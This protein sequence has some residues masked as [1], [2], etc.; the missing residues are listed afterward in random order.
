MFLSDASVKRPI[1]MGCL[2]IALSLLGINTYRT[3]NL[4]MMPR[5]DLPYITITTAYPGASPEE[6]ETDIAKRIEDE[7]VAID[8]LKHVTSTCMEDY[9]QTLLEFNL[10]IDVD[11][12]ATDVREKIDLI[13]SDLPEDV[14]DPIILKYDINAKPIITMAL[15]GD[16]PLDELYDYADNTL[17]DRISVLSG[18][19]DVDLIG[20]A[21]REVQILLDRE[22]LASR[23]LTTIDVVKAVSEGVRTIPSGRIREGETEYSVKFKAEYDEFKDIG[24]L[25]IVNLQGRRCY[26]RDLGRVEMGTEELRQRADLDGHPCVAIKVVKKSD[27]NAV[28]V[29]HKV[30]EVLDRINRDLPGGMKLVWVTDDGT[31]TEATNFSAWINVLQGIFLTAGILFLFL[32]NFRALMVVAVTMPVTVVIGIFFMG[33]I[34]L[35][36]NMPTLLAIGM[37]VGILVTNSIVV[38][39]AIVKHLKKTG[40]PK[41]AARKGAAESFIAVLASAGTNLVVLFPMSIMETLVGKFIESF[42]QT[43]LIMT[44]VSLFISFTL[45]PLLC[46]VILRPDREEKRNRL[47]RMESSWDRG[48]ERFREKYRRMLRFFEAHRWASILFV[49]SVAGLLILT[50]STAGKMGFNLVNEPDKG[51]I[52]V[53]LEFPTNYSLEFTTTRIAPVVEKLRSIPE[54]GHILTTIGK[55]AGTTGQ[56][57]EGVYLAQ[58]LLRFSEKT[59]RDL[60]LV[61]LADQIR[62]LTAN[63]PDSI[64][65][66]SLPSTMGG[67]DSAVEMEITG[68]KLETLDNLALETKTLAEKIPGILDPDTTVRAGKPELRITPDRAVLAD[69]SYPATTLGM[70]LRG[71]LEGI[72]AATFKKDARNYDITVQLDEVEGKDQV[73]SFL[74]P[75]G[76]GR[77]ITL[78]VLADIEERTTPIQIIRKDKLRVSKLYA[79]LGGRVALGTAVTRI[80]DSIDAK[81]LMPPGYSY[82]FTGRFETMTEGVAELGQATI[83]AVVLVILTLSAIL[84]SFRQPVF[85]MVAIPVALIGMVWPLVLFGE[86]IGI[87]VLMGGVMLIGIVVNN[88][89]LIMDQFNFHI[90]QGFPQHKA[91]I[92]AATER[93]RPI[94]MI[95]IAATL[96]MLPLAFGRGL[97]AE[98]RNATGISSAGGI[99][100][101]GIFTIF[102]IPILYDLFT[103]KGKKVRG[104]HDISQESE[105][106][107]I[108]SEKPSVTSELDNGSK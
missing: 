44:A 48:F 53:K 102:L 105:P 64:V 73:R 46:S 2:I 62:K 63:I 51:E 75:G 65:T 78:D 41:A 27:A 12:A 57:T 69:L 49:L 72:E 37:S 80:S 20:G 17:R 50:M 94:I 7:V 59:E 5:V 15:T 30:R 91:M 86:A 100:V 1:A 42:A 83:I 87:F 108:L 77:A 33:W 40:D 14:E 106:D 21:E 32:Y 8:G 43:L 68:N 18:V 81:D 61:D 29:V 101:S 58:I 6:I 79:G 31:F 25:E 23:G 45:T 22:A 39:E 89:I 103:R 66:V 36:L 99:L 38:L 4:E 24:N 85:I 98:M 84:E 76:S 19:A 16:A 90:S 10:E 34:D 95:T 11:I 107:C 71:N 60:S 88:A 93:L 9:C 96:G 97:G 104:L 56:S 13:R 3:I 92:A 28:S 26:L 67:Q 82:R 74:F 55:V 52:Y 54:V 47:R 35:T 70:T